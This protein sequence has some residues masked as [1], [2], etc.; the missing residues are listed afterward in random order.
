MYLIHTNTTNVSETY[1][2]QEHVDMITNMKLGE[3]LY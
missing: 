3:S 1:R 2:Q